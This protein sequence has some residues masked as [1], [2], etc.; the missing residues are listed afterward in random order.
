MKAGLFGIKNSNNDFTKESSWGKNIFNNAFP[1]ALACYMDNQGYRLVYLV[2]NEN[3]LVEKRYISVE[4]LFNVDIKSDNVFF[5]FESKFSPYNK[6]N[7]SNILPGIDLVIKEDEKDITPL[8]IKLTTLPDNV[9]CDLT[10]DKYGSE[11]VVR[12]DTIVYQAFSIARSFM[13]TR[14]VLLEELQ[15]TYSKVK[16]WGN[17]EDVLLYVADIKNS[18]NNIFTKYSEFQKPLLMQ[19]IWKTVGKSAAFSDDCLD[20]FVWSDFSLS[21]LYMKNNLSTKKIDRPT[22]TMI[23]LFLMLYQFAKNGKF[24]HKYIIDTYTFDTKNDKAF[25]ITGNATNQLMSCNELTHPRIKKTEI[26]NIILG[27]GKVYL[28][29]ERRFDAVLRANVGLLE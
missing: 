9:T 12:P 4:E 21:R 20:I 23:W 5:A 1:V 26:K 22:R 3:L 28:S 2:L 27:D 14:Q 25:S 13:N 19:P 24:D 10:E 8:E 11:I 18:L 15:E 29:P 6:F 16:D 7:G 17:K